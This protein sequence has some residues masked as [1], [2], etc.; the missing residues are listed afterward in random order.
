MV[1]GVVWGITLFQG[2][3]HMMTSWNEAVKRGNSATE[4]KVEDSDP[5]W[6]SSPWTIKRKVLGPWA[7]WTQSKVAILEKKRRVDDMRWHWRDKSMP[8]GHRFNIL[9]FITWGMGSTK[10][11]LT[12]Q[13]GE[14]TGA[15]DNK[16]H[17]ERSG[18]S[19]GD[20]QGSMGS[21][22]G[23]LSGN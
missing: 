22:A 14:L 7:S 12:L 10:G 19:W 1:A 23:T 11:W 9:Y 21:L 3:Y 6:K 2:R 18:G 13:R 8:E 20:Y 16:V 4:S 15:L 5:Q 17:V